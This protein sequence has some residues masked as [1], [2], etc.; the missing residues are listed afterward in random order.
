MQVD[1]G[2]EKYIVTEE[3]VRDSK[4]LPPGARGYEEP[5]ILLT[6]VTPTCSRFPKPIH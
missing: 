6:S 3:S 5:K 4:V 2:K 1:Y